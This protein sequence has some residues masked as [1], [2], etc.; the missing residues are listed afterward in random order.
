MKQFIYLAIFLFISSIY[1][2]ENIGYQK[3][4]S[5]ILDLVDVQLAPSVLLDDH[6]EFM[7]LLYRNAFKS[8][9][10]LSQ[11]ELRLAGLRIDPKTNIGSRVTYSNNVEIKNLT[12]K[13]GEPTQVKGLPQ[14]ARLSNFNWSPDQKKIALTNTTF[15]GEEIWML[16]LQSATVS[17]LTEA[18]VNANLRD[19]I[20]WFEDSQSVLVKMVLKKS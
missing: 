3:P 6:K 17:K 18:T 15:K 4:P 10:D 11:E 16:D 14:N 9:E 19:V 12:V 2:Q 20:N 13:N 7:I 8:I 5:E 1:A